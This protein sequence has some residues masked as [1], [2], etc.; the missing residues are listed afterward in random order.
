MNDL[1]I[2]LVSKAMLTFND[3][4]NSV[5]GEQISH[6]ATNDAGLCPCKALARI[7][8]VHLRLQ[9]ADKTTPI[10]VYYHNRQQY[11]TTPQLITNTLGHSAGDLE[12][13][14]GIAPWLLSAR[15]LRPGGATALLCANIDPNIMQFPSHW[16][17]DTMLRYLRI[18]AQSNSRHLAQQM[19]QAS[20][21]T[22]APQALAGA[23]AAPI[24]QQAPRLH[25]RRLTCRTL[26]L[27]C[28]VFLL[29]PELLSHPF[30]HDPRDS[31]LAT[32][33]SRG[34][35]TRLATAAQR[36]GAGN[37]WPVRG[38][39]TGISLGKPTFARTAWRSGAGNGW[40]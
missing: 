17:S 3:Q 27:A 12:S 36:C 30:L 13:A 9:D 20:H 33:I 16:Q 6:T 38:L 1:N 11:Y 14:T 21:Y 40:P 25:H 10:Y 8:L 23:T 35:G 26:H 7:C 39:A 5:R 19:L 18:V 31:G 24:P 34:K 2:D 22:F 4:E 29:P 28:C 32:G 37:G 15:S